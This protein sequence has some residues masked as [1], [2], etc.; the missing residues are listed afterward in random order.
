M[1]SRSLVKIKVIKPPVT[2]T[3]RPALFCPVQA[4]NSVA[5]DALP[6][7]KALIPLIARFMGPT[8]GPSGA[9]RTQV[10]PC[11]PHEPCYLDHWPQGDLNLILKM[12][13]SVLFC[14]WISSNLLITK[15]L[16]ECHGTWLMISQH[17]LRSRGSTNGLVPSGNKPLL[18]PMLIQIFVAIW[19]H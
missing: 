2:S 17:W 3:D 14:W 7:V 1:C 12:Q 16:D 13:Y 18:E 5:C 19:R 11:W 4:A 6:E 10:G 8:R 9:D 15:P